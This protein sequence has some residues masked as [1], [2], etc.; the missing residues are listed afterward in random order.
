MQARQNIKIIIGLGN[1]EPQYNRTYHNVGALFIDYLTIIQNS[2]CNLSVGGQ[3]SKKFKSI[4]FNNLI[5]ARPLTFM[6]ESGVA[7]KEALKYFKLKPANLLIVHDDSDIEISKYKISFGRGS[8]GHNGVESIIKTLKTKNFWRVR[9]G[10][11]KKSKIRLKA[12]DFVLKKINKDDW[13]IL[14]KT[15]EKIKK[16]LEITM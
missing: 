13:E 11:R 2:K 15:F 1:P 16:K 8:A 6:N 7:V 10:I 5:I 3:N 12:S 9:I 14:N 4:K